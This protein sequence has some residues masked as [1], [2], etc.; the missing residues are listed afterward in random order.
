[1]LSP[2]V[3]SGNRLASLTRRWL[4]LLAAVLVLACTLS[5]FEFS[6]P[7]TELVARTRAMMAV[8]TGLGVFKLSGHV[9]GF[10]ILGGLLAAVYEMRLQ[11]C[12]FW[13]FAI[14][15]AAFCLTLEML[16]FF[17]ES[18]HA[19]ITDLICNFSGLLLGAIGSL[20]WQRGRVV[21]VRLADLIHRHSL[22]VQKGILVLGSFVWFSAGLYPAT[23]VLKL[24]WNKDSQLVV[25]NETDHSRPW[26][27]EIRFLGIYARGFDAREAKLWTQGSDNRLAR[28]AG[29]ES[30]LLLGY[31]FT[32]GK[33]AEVIPEGL[34]AT[35]DLALDIAPESTWAPDRGGILLTRPSFLSSRGP[36]FKVTEA[37]MAAGELSVAAVVRP[38]HRSQTGPAR[39][40]SLSEG[41]W[42]RNFMLG[43]ENSDLVFRVRNGVNGTN[44]LQHALWIR[45]AL[46]DALH[47]IVAVYDH[48]VSQMVMDG[49]QLSPVVDLREPGAYLQLGT[50]VGGRAVA[51]LLLTLTF[52]LPAATMAESLAFGRWRLVLA[53]LLTFCVGSLPYVATCLCVGGPWRWAHFLWLGAVLL[54]AYP[55]CSWYVNRPSAP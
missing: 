37:I 6:F 34:L 39:I 52:A 2:S 50:G 43:Q 38:L 36:D 11:Q 31:D 45:D 12:P 21:R 20:R 48:G 46:Q 13:S 24:D 5:P 47:T 10:C 40:I 8:P 3:I 4:L 35:E 15:A 33:T 19:R 49:K 7:L 9:A 30:R 23:G 17:A 44:G 53:G 16:Q 54:L 29:N 25:G 1:M 14:G 55:L 26:L 41:I 32:S 42:S 51:A 27:G 28:D 22:R 18:R